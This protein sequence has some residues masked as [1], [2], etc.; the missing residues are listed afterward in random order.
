MPRPRPGVR[1]P[2][3]GLAAWL[4]LAGWLAACAPGASPTSAPALT[5]LPALPTLTATAPPTATPTALPPTA[6]RAATAADLTPAA[7]EAATATPVIAGTPEPCRNDAEFEADLT[8]PDDAQYLPGQTFVKKWS[9]R[10]TGTCDWGPGYRLV[11]VTGEPLTASPGVAAQTEF[12]LYPAR[13]GAPAVWEIPMRA[14]D[15]SGVY[16]GRWQARDPQGELFGD[17]VFVKIEV[18]PLPT[19]AP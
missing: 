14:P 7:T 15:A 19:P 5:P 17:F 16:T 6:T 13:A 10:N 2:G 12:A 1:R 9:V 11:F 8:V 3:A 4:A 18:I